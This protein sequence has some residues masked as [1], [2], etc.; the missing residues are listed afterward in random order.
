MLGPGHELECLPGSFEQADAAPVGQIDCL[1]SP[2]AVNMRK[3]VKVTSV[4]LSREP[5]LSSDMFMNPYE[6]AKGN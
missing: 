2:Q 5:Q 4:I 1:S 6:V 3:K